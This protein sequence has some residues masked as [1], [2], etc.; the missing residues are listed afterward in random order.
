MK[1]NCYMTEM[2][3]D[4]PKM[5]ERLEEAGVPSEQARAHASVLVD[6]V[7]AAEASIMDRAATKQ[8][9]E[10]E[11]NQI[12]IALERFEARVEVRFAG[13]DA[14]LAELKTDLFRWVVSVGILQTAL[15]AA[16]VLK[17]TS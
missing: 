16:L 3:F 12:K 15:I 9:V 11:L 8:A 2:R 6:V 7:S 17:L 14:R 13:V 4:T 10:H 1:Q 5:V